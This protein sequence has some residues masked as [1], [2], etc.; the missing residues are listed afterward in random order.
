MFVACSRVRCLSDKMFDPPFAY[1]KLVRSIEQ[2]LA[3]STLRSVSC[4][5]LARL[6]TCWYANGRSNI[7]SENM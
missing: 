2:S 3:S 6:A 4:M 7:L 1:R 5:L